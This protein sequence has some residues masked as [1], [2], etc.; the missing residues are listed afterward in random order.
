MCKTDKNSRAN[1]CDNNNKTTILNQRHKYETYIV[2]LKLTLNVYSMAW[3]GRK[4][5][6][7]FMFLHKYK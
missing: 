3:V 2:A 1:L 6:L 4:I 5:L 7:I